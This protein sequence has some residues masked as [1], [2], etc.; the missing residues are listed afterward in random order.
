MLNLGK[1]SELVKY[2][3]VV[4][5]QT[6]R[7]VEHLKD[8]EVGD[9]VTYESLSELVGRDVQTVGRGWLTSA[10][11][12]LLKE[13]GQ[14]WGTVREVGIKRLNSEESVKLGLDYVKRSRRVVKRGG[15]IASSV[16]YQELEESARKTHQSIIAASQVMQMFLRDSGLK[17]LETKMAE[18]PVQKLPKMNDL[19]ELFEN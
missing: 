2:I 6:M 13:H 11:K 4:A 1:S 9:E 17:K 18:S 5:K 8:M 12:R 15:E 10:R 7:I 14:V 16:E 3:P 19:L